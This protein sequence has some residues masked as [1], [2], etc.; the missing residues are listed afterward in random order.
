MLESLKTIAKNG[1]HLEIT[2][3]VIPGLNDDETT[4]EKV[5][6]WISDELGPHVPLHLSRYFP[7]YKLNLSPTP[8][9]KLEQLF[10]IANSH[11]KFVYLG[12]VNDKQHSSTFCTKCNS[13]L[14]ERNRYETKIA[15]T[16][17]S[18]TCKVCGTPA[19]IVME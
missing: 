12:N 18:G 9:E 5:V 2:N 1:N 6:R 17:F 8:T 13:L 3:L 14:I 16:E 10:Q 7:K 19:H 15:Q 4:F 11:L